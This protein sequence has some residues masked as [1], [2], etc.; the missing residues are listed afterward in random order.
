MALTLKAPAEKEVKSLLDLPPEIRIQIY[1]YLFEASRLSCDTPHLSLPHCGYSIC[2]CLFPRHITTTCHQL[3]QETM[4]YLTTSTTLE[5][6]GS[7]DKIIKMPLPYLSSITQVIVLDAKPFSLRPFQVEKLPALEIL[8]LRN[9]TV[10]CKFYDETFLFSRH[11]DQAMFDMALFNLKRIASSLLDLC[12]QPRTFNIHLC[13]QFVVN[14][15]SDET[16][17]S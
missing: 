9:I 1:T 4:P 16:I 8:E 5:V 2:T 6:A 10:W 13:C 15:L 7:L 11:A 12:C 14:S 3:R 17:V